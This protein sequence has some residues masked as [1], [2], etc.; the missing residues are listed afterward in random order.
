MTLTLVRCGGELKENIF[1]NIVG[2]IT[3]CYILTSDAP[4]LT[5]EEFQIARSQ[6]ISFKG[7][8]QTDWESTPMDADRAIIANY[9]VRNIT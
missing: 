7:P 5:P 4:P 3:Q 8:L 1:K 9:F 6:K 2:K